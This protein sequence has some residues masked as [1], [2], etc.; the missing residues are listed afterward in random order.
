M[1]SVKQYNL[2][3]KRIN[4]YNV[5]GGI[6]CQMPRCTDRTGRRKRP[7]HAC[8]ISRSRKRNCW[9]SPKSSCT[10]LRRL[11]GILVI[12]FHEKA[13]GFTQFFA[14]TR[15]HLD[16]NA[17][18]GTRPFQM[19][20]LWHGLIGIYILICELPDP[21]PIFTVPLPTWQTRTCS[22]PVL[23]VARSTNVTRQ[24]LIFHTLRWVTTSLEPASTVLNIPSP[25]PRRGSIYTPRTMAGTLGA[26]PTSPFLPPDATPESMYMAVQVSEILGAS[27]FL[28]AS[29]FS[30]PLGRWAW[31]LNRKRSSP[32][33]VTFT[34]HGGVHFWMGNYPSYT[35]REKTN[36]RKMNFFTCKHFSEANREGHFLSKLSLNRPEIFCWL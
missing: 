36:V 2:R 27:D 18:A 30:T 31:C 1:K 8:K 32:V 3:S 6:F 34:M 12:K 19:I 5:L 9:L 22:S 21:K 20:W 33:E 24:H 14:F 11:T 16:G 15:G 25:S 35:R 28:V 10:I 4:S 23:R 29:T 17:Y 7:F 26:Q 13:N